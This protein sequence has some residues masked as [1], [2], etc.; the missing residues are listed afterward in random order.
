MSGP[1]GSEAFLLLKLVSKFR[2]FSVFVNDRARGFQG[3]FASK[4][5]PGILRIFT[6]RRR[7]VLP[8]YLGESFFWKTAFRCFNVCRKKNIQQQRKDIGGLRV[9]IDVKISEKSGFVAR[10]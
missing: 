6:E 9:R 8:K 10:C 1:V 7:Q 2:E 4:M 5:S 3:V